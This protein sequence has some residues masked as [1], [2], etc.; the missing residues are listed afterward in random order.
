RGRRAR[1][2]GVAGSRGDARR[3]RHHPAHPPRSRA[4]GD[5]H[6]PPGRAGGPLTRT[7][8]SLIVKREGL[9]PSRSTWLLGAAILAAGVVGADLLAPPYPLLRA[10]ELLLYP[11]AL[12]LAYGGGLRAGMAGVFLAATA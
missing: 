10:P 8:A 3:G 6:P 2:G 4:P 9:Q 7:E 11:V 12:L 1:L 5:H